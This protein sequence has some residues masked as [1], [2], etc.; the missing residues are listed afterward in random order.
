[1]TKKIL[2][3]DGL[4]IANRAFYGIPLLSNKA[5]NYTNAIY[6]FLNIMLSMI[7]KE[8]PDLIGVA[9]DVSAPTFRHIEFK[10]YKGTRKGMP[11]E[12][13]SQIPV[14]KEVLGLMTIHQIEKAGFEADDLLGTLAKKAETAGYQ[15]VVI[16]GDRDLL[17]ITSEN[18]ELKIPKTKLSGTEIESYY[19]KDVLEKYEVTPLAFIDVKGLM[20]DTSDNIPGVPGV[21]EKTAIKLIKQYGNMENLYDHLD[22]IKQKKLNENLTTYR[23]QAF[24]S[25]MLATILCDVD[26]GEVDW[27]DFEYTLQPSSEAVEMLKA[28]EFKKIIAKLPAADVAPVEQHEFEMFTEETLSAFVEQCKQLP[29][30]ISYRLEGEQLELGF[31]NGQRI[32]WIDCD[33][34]AGCLKKLFN[35][36]QMKWVIYDSKKLRHYLGRQGISIL[37]D[38]FDCFIAAYLL[39]PTEATYT[40][41]DLLDVYLDQAPIQQ[42]KEEPLH[43]WKLYGTIKDKL[44]AYEM[45]SLFEE[46]EMPLVE[47]LYDMEREG[48][49][50]DKKALET[51]GTELTGMIEVVEKDIYETCGEVFNINSPKQLGVVLF[52]KMGIP[53]IKKTKTGYST[54]AEVL[55]KLKDDYPV[56][57]KILEYRQYMKLK[58]TYVDGLLQLLTSESKIHS[59]FNQTV[60][61]TG[62]I[63]STEPN[64]QNIPIRLP[65]GRQIRK[66]FVPRSEDYIFLDADYS[67][68]ELRVLAAIAEDEKLIHAF[69]NGL[70]IHTLTASEVFHTPFDEVTALQ[71]S[72]AKAVNFGIVYGISAFALAEDLK[73]SQ[74]E[75][76]AYISGYFEKYPAIKNYLEYVVSFAKMHGYVETIFNRRRDIPEM[77]SKN[78]NIREFGKRVAMNTPIQGAAADIIKIAMIRVAGALKSKTLKSKLILTV[79]D[80]LLLEVYKPELEEVA[81]LLKY[82]MEQAVNLAVPLSVDVHSGQNWLEA[83]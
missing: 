82:E 30:S 24:T 51:Y 4:S 26:L 74:K 10:E 71:R 23:E 25:K 68:I 34:H 12:L 28:L 73:I 52:E 32:G 54:A 72:N 21:G 20:G 2:L 61:A 59:T 7:E 69:T 57:E 35:D 53:P 81:Q 40:M 37:G 78:F 43:L 22:E 79:H 6:G 33:K 5:G 45:T 18:V 76:D 16:S 47:V 64:L 31:S 14:L 50:V 3:L 19:A 44:E 11:D 67:Q 29:I 8:K 17:Q 38:V 55:E 70:D 48:I 9:F 49:S 39:S 75:A 66:V 36:S 62:R 13:R 27:A 65:L 42:T 60:T 80:E 41:D 56:V 46:I 63:S 15:V 83:K 1:M 58:S 77:A